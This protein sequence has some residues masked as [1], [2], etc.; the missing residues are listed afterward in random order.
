MYDVR[1]RI[2]DLTI[3]NVR[4]IDRREKEKMKK[5]CVGSDAPH[6]LMKERQEERLSLS[7]VGE[8]G[9]VEALLLL[10]SREKI[11]KPSLSGSDSF[12]RYAF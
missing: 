1:F 4:F 7:Y 12:S 5:S 9:E 10:F 2:Y 11:E 8:A 6:T 3:D